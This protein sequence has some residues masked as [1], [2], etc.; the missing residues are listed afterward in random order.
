MYPT[1]GGPGQNQQQGPGQRQW[2]PSQQSPQ[3]QPPQQHPQYRH[4]PNIQQIAPVNGPYPPRQDPHPQNPQLRPDRPEMAAVQHHPG[5]Y[6][7]PQHPGPYLPSPSAIYPPPPHQDYRPP[8]QPGQGGVQ[9]SAPRQRTAIACKYCRRRKIRC[10]GFENSEDGRCS[11][12]VRFNQEC[13]FTPVSS[14]AQAFVPAQALYGRGGR[15]GPPQPQP[16]QLYGPYGNPLPHQHDPYAHAYHQGAPYGWY[17]PPN[18]PGPYG[19][20]PPPPQMGYDP[21][22]QNGAPRRRDDSNTPT[23]PPP[24]GPPNSHPPPQRPEDAPGQGYAYPDPSGY[25]PNPSAQ[26]PTSNVGYGQQPHPYYPHQ[27][28]PPQHPQQGPQ[29]GSPGSASAY[30]YEPSRNSNSPHSGPGYP[31][32]AAQPPGPPPASGPRESRTPPSG[33]GE[34]GKNGMS[35]HEIVR[36]GPGNGN[37][38]GSNGERSAADNSMVSALNR[39]PPRR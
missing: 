2:D 30:S 25:A 14:Q 17:P 24:S 39:P 11:N 5:Y 15:T 33:N 1:G 36:D 28:P 7:P 6:P 13:V 3:G 31:N 29:R 8:P 34:H 38:D 16:R 26:S 4:D 32:Y 35:I 20:P 22:L 10:S 18:Q 19:H 21:N 12:C 27:P 37:R 9:Q 23:L